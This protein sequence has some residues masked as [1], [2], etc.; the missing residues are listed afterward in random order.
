MAT[1]AY[2]Q[3]ETREVVEIWSGRRW[4]PAMIARF[5]PGKTYSRLCALE[6][7]GLK[8][9]G[10]PKFHHHGSSL[11]GPHARTSYIDPEREAAADQIRERIQALIRDENEA[12]RQL[13][14]LYGV[15]PR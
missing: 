2:E 5:D 7:D 1:K 9:D 10:S 4:T 15:N 11:E 12:R 14:E 8:K 6:P 3:L 13:A